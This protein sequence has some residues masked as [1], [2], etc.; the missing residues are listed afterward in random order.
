[1]TDD[2]ILNLIDEERAACFGTRS[3][4]IGHQITR[5]PAALPHYTIEME[6]AL[7]GLTLP[8]SLSRHNV[9]L[10]GNYLGQIG[11]AKILELASRMPV[12][13]EREGSWK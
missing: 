11:L 12:T 1:M 10:V 8:S 13:L 6:R 3:E 7:H 2:D 5:W 9:F 4:R